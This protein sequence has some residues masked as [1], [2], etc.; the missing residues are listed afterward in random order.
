MTQFLRLS[1]L[2]FLTFLFNQSLSTAQDP[3]PGGFTYGWDNYDQTEINGL[4]SRTVD[5]DHTGLRNISHAPPEGIHPRVFFGPDEIPDIINRLH[6]TESGRVV[7]KL[8]HAYTSLMHMGTQNFDVNANYARDDFNNKL[9]GNTGFWN[10]EPAYTALTNEEMTVWDG[11]PIKR[12]HMTAC[13]MAF[14]AFECLL[15]AGTTDSVTNLTYTERADKL[16]TA[17]TFWASLAINDPEVNPNS[18]NFNNFGGTHMALAY[19]LH[20]NSMTSA[21]QNL[22]REALVKTIPEAPR[23]GGNL[24]AYAN[25]S[26]WTTLNS[27]EI[28]PNLAIE[29]ETGYKPELTERWMRAYHTFINYGWYPSGA[30]YEGLGKNYQFVTTMIACAKRGYSLLG[31]PHVRAYGEKF[32]PAILQPFGHGYTS[33]DVWGGSGSDA[34]V[35]GYKF[36]TSDAVGLKWAFPDSEPVDFV[37]RNYIEKWTGDNSVGYTYQQIR[38]DDSYYNYLLPAAIFASDY[39]SG[40]WNS[41]A[42][43]VLEEDYFASDRGLAVL[44]SGKQADDLAVQFH[45]RQDMGGHTHGDRN[46]FTLSAN[47]RIWIRKSFGGSQFQPTWFHSTILVDDQGVAVGDP[48]GDKCRQPGKVVHWESNNDH[49]VVAGDV[50]YAYN[51]DWHWSPQGIN[52]D[53]PW[54]GSNG[55]E[56]VTETWNDFQYEPKTEPHFDLPFYEFPHWHQPAKYER[57]IKR[58]VNTLEKVIRTTA[59]IKGENPF[60][61]IVD[62]VKK[63]EEI[64]NYKWLAQVARDLTIEEMVINLE[65]QNY[66]NDIILKEPE[67]TGNRK[68]LVR[69]LE[70]NGYDGTTAPA[71]MDTLQYFDYFTGNPYNANPNWIRP[72][73]IVESNSVAPQFKV[74]LFPFEAGEELPTTS[75]NQ[76]QDT[77]TISIGTA[78]A[79][80]IAFQENE[81]GRTE[82]TF[83]DE[84][85]DITNEPIAV[86]KLFPNP[87]SNYLQLTFTVEQPMSTF[88]LSDITGKIV[89]TQQISGNTAQVDVSQLPKG[90]YVYSLQVNDQPIQE[91]KIAIQ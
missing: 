89:Q 1:I 65:N 26:N 66:R 27:F 4:G 49:S 76:N 38:P 17:M 70:N 20:Y 11:I 30:G 64:H 86:M 18:D 78:D 88:I 50:T 55:W 6:H 25:T 53:H 83:V 44:R 36:N 35:G 91:G 81:T 14:E 48:D 29:G 56:A 87:A 7:K 68:L 40:D 82:I 24:P 90:I 45:C 77:L 2:F 9:I 60:V 5:F 58:P 15:F 52:T 63:D 74:L 33:Y 42:E 47:G 34:E 62:D 51:W 69:I 59:M 19:D 72:R 12:K 80:L 8:I 43:E 37:W 21:Q 75:W 61:L 13:M 22:V 31:H 39:A 57:M 16:S 79:Q 41:Q 54:L 46:D 10:V 84:T 71:R 32:L 73:L 23:H 3:Q 85:V 67:A 28:I